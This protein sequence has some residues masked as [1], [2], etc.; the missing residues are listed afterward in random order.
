MF[1]VVICLFLATPLGL[2]DLSFPAMDWTQA[3]WYWERKLEEDAILCVNQHKSHTHPWAIYT[4]GHSQR[5]TAKAFKNE[6]T[7]ELP[8]TLGK[9]ELMNWT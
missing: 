6:L 7:L 3:E 1:S 5:S 9:T 2:Q 8:T 4:Q